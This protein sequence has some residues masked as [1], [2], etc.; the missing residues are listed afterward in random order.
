MHTINKLL[1]NNLN[2][3]CYTNAQAASAEYGIFKYAFKY[4]LG[5]DENSDGCIILQK[6][7]QPAA[8]IDELPITVLLKETGH[9]VVLLDESGKG[10]QIDALI[11]GSFF[12]LKNLRN[13]TNVFQRI[14]KDCQ[15]A[16]SKGAQNVIININVAL[17]EAELKVILRRL[18]KSPQVEKLKM[19]WCI[20]DMELW[21]FDLSDFK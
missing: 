17:N 14:K 19:F 3:T 6:G 5:Y 18:A 11:D 4:A 1:F 20:L 8:L 21:K 16:L 15:N 2:D 13:A 10:K 9:F 12:E 7:H